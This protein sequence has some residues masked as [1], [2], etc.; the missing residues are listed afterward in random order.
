M[1]RICLVIAVLLLAP[2]AA[3]KDVRSSSPAAYGR[4]GPDGVEQAILMLSGASSAEELD[5]DEVERYLHFLEHPLELNTASR[6]RL[7]SSGLLSAYRV[8]SLLD[9]RRRC[10]DVL[11]FTELAAVDGFGEAFVSTLRPFV[12]LRSERAPGQGPRDGHTLEQAFVLRTSYRRSR[13]DDWALAGRYDIS[14]DGR[15]ELGLALKEAYGTKSFPPQTSSFHLSYEGGGRLSTLV[16]GAFNCRFGQGLA[17]WSGFSPSTLSKASAV[18]RNPTLIAPYRGYDAFSRESSA[19][20]GAAASISFDAARRGSE[21]RCS[22]M[23]SAFVAHPGTGGA[24]CSIYLPRGQ[25]GFTALASATDCKASADLRFNL[26][27]VDLFGEAAF[28]FK[29]LKP[30]AILGL[31]TSPFDD[32]TLAFL[33]RYYPSDWPDA[34]SSAL[35]SG[36]RCRDEHAVSLLMDIY[37]D[38]RRHLVNIGLDAAFRPS[39]HEAGASLQ[40]AMQYRAILLWNWNCLPEL[41]LAMRADFRY[42]G[43][44]KHCL[45]GNLR[46]ELAWDD[47]ANLLRGRLDAVYCSDFSYLAFIEAG[48]RFEFPKGCLLTLYLRQGAFHAD[49]WEDRIYCSQRDVPGSFNVPAMYGRGLWTGLVSG[50]KLPSGIS[51]HLYGNLLV[52]P[53]KGP[54]YELNKERD[55]KFELRIQLNARL[56]NNRQRLLNQRRPG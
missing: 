16:I 26:R 8:A 11:S 52:Y 7:L 22:G 50:L 42:R 10:G 38:N 41:A 45:R 19:L 2:A 18:S 14:L 13:D 40:A 39:K 49:A 31:R 33:L 43:W 15:Y 54:L 6:A 3:A 48:R 55:G 53:R 28:D 30:A 46:T 47:G 27:G 21:S 36:S 20:L 56:F 32:A 44:D 23:L 29:S 37:A 51:L 9:Y 34:L 1:E 12:S 4:P 35:S 5:A 24:N 17:L 25:F